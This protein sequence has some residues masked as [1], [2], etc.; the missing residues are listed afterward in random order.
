MADIY[1][2]LASAISGGKPERVTI[3]ERR[4]AKEAFWR[5]F[6]Q[7]VELP[8]NEGLAS[9]LRAVAPKEPGL[10]FA[11]LEWRSR[12][13]GADAVA[14][15]SQDG[16]AVFATGFMGVLKF[17]LDRPDDVKAIVNAARQFADMV[18]QAQ[19]EFDGICDR[20]NK[21]P[22]PRWSGEICK[23]CDPVQLCQG[24]FDLHTAEVAADAAD[25]AQAA[26]A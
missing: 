8:G 24:C 19:R 18:E 4:T 16:P 17:R 14:S 7:V 26:G 23:T 22:A 1:K 3:Q 13:N 9:A 21:R 25:D 11:N 10:Q 20:C 5:A 12:W 2:E 6:G 15:Y